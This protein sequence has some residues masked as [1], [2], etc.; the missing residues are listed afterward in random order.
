LLAQNIQWELSK[1]SKVTAQQNKQRNEEIY[2]RSLTLAMEELLSKRIKNKV[3]ERAQEIRE[4]WELQN[5][6]SH[7]QARLKDK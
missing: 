4:V 7:K 3:L 2:S 1:K 5:N 6:Q